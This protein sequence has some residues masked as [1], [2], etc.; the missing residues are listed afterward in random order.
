MKITISRE[1]IIHN[2]N[3]INKI[4]SPSIFRNHENA[5]VTTHKDKMIVGKNL[6]LFRKDKINKRTTHTFVKAVNKNRQ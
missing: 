2:Q 3:P 6:T 1:L 5:E 4:L